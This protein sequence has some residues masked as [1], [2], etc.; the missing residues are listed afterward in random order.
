MTTGRTRLNTPRIKWS[1][2]V[3]E[4]F[5]CLDWHRS[6]WG[7][8]GTEKQEGQ[9]KKLLH[10]LLALPLLAASPF[11]QPMQLTDKQMHKVSAGF[12]SPEVH[13]TGGRVL[14]LF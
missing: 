10:G 4:F 2:S 14:A 1:N 6:T 9:M 12:S 7:V 3:A 8:H 13:N 5:T 11:A